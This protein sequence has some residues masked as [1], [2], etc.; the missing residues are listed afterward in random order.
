MEYRQL[1]NTDLQVSLICL[2][3]MTWGQQNTEAE[4]FE[5][6]DYAFEQGINFIDTA[7]MYPVPPRPETQ[8]ATE[9][10]VGNWLK[11][12]GLRDKIVL[13]SKVAGRGDNNPGMEHVRGGPRLS[14]EHIALA[15]EDSL[16]RLQTDMID[17][18]QVHWPE[19]ATNFF[20]QLTYRHRETGE[21]DIR[22]TLEAL[23]KLVEQGKVRYIGLS[24]ETPWGLMEYLR[25]AR[26]YN[27][28]GVVSVQNPYSLLNR[29]YEVGLA[30][31]SMREQVG[32]LAYSPLAF[33]VLSGKYLNGQRPEG[34]R[35]SLFERFSRYTNPQ[36]EAATEQYVA[37]AREQGLDPAQMALAFVNQQPFVASNII[38]ATS[39]E[40]LKANIASVE[41]TLS[42]EQ[43]KAI[44]ELHQ[45]QPF[46]AP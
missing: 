8:G 45:R 11:A 41:L 27:L 20:G 38:G 29:S 26:E 9:T 22:E 18:Y 39:M 28:P 17:L 30:E 36:A 5:Q 32:L 3:T 24:N 25:L 10:I 43:L 35:L 37:L 19:R 13:A 14:A 4:G 7:E 40:Q 16:K 44:D 1:G 33:G 34:A 6:M 31:M 2:G 46:P 15:C 12:R 21:I 23:A 42:K